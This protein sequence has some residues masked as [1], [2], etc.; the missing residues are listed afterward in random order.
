MI[1]YYTPLVGDGQV[2]LDTGLCQWRHVTK[3]QEWPDVEE[4]KI[5]TIIYLSED[6]RLVEVVDEWE[7]WVEAGVVTTCRETNEPTIRARG[8]RIPDRFISLLSPTDGRPI[9]LTQTRR[10]ILEA[11][12]LARRRLTQSGLL[13]VLRKSGPD[14][15]ENTLRIELAKLVQAG[16]LDNDQEARPRGYGVTGPGRSI[17]EVGDGRG[18]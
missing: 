7:V 9:T 15:S 17:L 8:I 3:H 12:A 16:W 13:S 4:G 14:F 2:R 10:R 5:C 1:L 11:V 18:L 6:G